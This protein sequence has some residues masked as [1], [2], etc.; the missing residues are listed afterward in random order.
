MNEVAYLPRKGMTGVKN[1]KIL[2]AFF[3]VWV[4]HIQAITTAYYN[5]RGVRTRIDQRSKERYC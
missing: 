4:L 2:L 5:E 3:F 1:K